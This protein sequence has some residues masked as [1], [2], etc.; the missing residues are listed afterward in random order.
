MGVY[1]MDLITRYINFY[2]IIKKRNG[3][4]PFATFN[5]HKH[6]KPGTHW[7]SFMD[8]HPPP[9]Q[10]KKKLLLFDSLGVEGFKFFIA[11]NDENIKDELLYNF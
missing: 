2:K 7:W 1:S 9:P 5:T 11:D 3:K 10:K 6:N 8:V 4:Y